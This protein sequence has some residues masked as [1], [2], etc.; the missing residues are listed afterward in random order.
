MDEFIYKQIA[1]QLL[2]FKNAHCVLK[3]RPLDFSESLESKKILK[4]NKDQQV[5]NRALV[6]KG[7]L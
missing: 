5:S 3:P 4:T 2:T 6:Y 7:T 1:T